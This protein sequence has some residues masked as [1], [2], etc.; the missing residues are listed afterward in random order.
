MISKFSFKTKLLALVGF[1]ISISI[2][3]GA[4][5][6]FSL[7]GVNAKYNHIVKVN[8][9]NNMALADMENDVFAIRG[10]VLRLALYFD[11]PK[12]REDA[13][14]RTID[15]IKDYEAKDKTYNDITFVAGEEEKY[16]PVNEVWKNLKVYTEQIIAFAK[17]PNK[18][19]YKS[20]KAILDDKYPP[21]VT[22]FRSSM[23]TL[24]DFQDREA[25]FWSTS[26]E[27][28]AKEAIILEIILIFVGGLTGGLVGYFFIRNISNSL[29]RITDAVGS[30][31]EQ[32]SSASVQISQ[33]ADTLSSTAQE[34]ASSLEETSASL[35]EIAG[36]A[37]SNVTGAEEADHSA[38]EVYKMT[39]ETRESMKELS[40]AM[41]TIL[42][43]NDRIVKL[44]K[45]IEEIGEKT[46][47]IDDI[48]FKTQL[49]SFNASVEAERAGEH[50]RG[51]AVVAQEVGN[52]AQMSGK[53]ATEIASIVKN[54]IKE[55]ESVAYENK[56]HVTSGSE[57]AD[58]TKTK[59]EEVLTKLNN[60]IELVSKITAASKEQSQGVGQIT[61]AIEQLNQST[62]ETAG[63][64]EESASAAAELTGQA[65]SLMGL[66]DELKAIV[67]GDNLTPNNSRPKFE[68]HVQSTSKT[69][70]HVVLNNVVP[71][72]NKAV[73]PAASYASTAPVKKVSGGDNWD[74]L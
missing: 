54:S 70:E 22:G 63:T 64:A 25:N 55:A 46:E 65:E 12:E 68:K 42:A 10:N 31:G 2:I 47:I 6:Y 50:G 16:K 51:F 71:M 39:E 20:I 74:K 49:L 13:I 72:K 23:L 30:A 43:S 33:S 59:M 45:I 9:A 38:Q 18:E 67:H 53:A 28:A 1:L 24:Q 8:M 4:V 56:E 69:V 52:L 14:K 37:N 34:Q 21:L 5:S 61:N 15:R 57:L 19:S 58:S 29:S 60:V 32:V 11:Q 40:E 3:V 44:V 7:K 35:T 73:K 41:G 26:A 66:V 27:N 36:M 62:Q 17:N 48:V